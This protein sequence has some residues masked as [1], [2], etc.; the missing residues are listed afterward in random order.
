MNTELI[1]RYL[2]GIYKSKEERDYKQGD[3][4]KYSNNLFKCIQPH[5]TQSDDNWNPINTPALWKKI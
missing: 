2:G 4:V 3:I 5:T 1:F